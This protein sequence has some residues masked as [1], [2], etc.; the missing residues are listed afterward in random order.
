[1][2]DCMHEV[3]KK[4]SSHRN[5]CSN[6]DALEALSTW[7]NTGILIYTYVI[8]QASMIWI[9]IIRVSMSRTRQSNPCFQSPSPVSMRDKLNLKYKKKSER[10]RQRRGALGG[11]VKTNVTEPNRVSRV[12]SIDPPPSLLSPLSLSIPCP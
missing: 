11:G 8:T 6:F 2:A 4:Y 12:G 7:L 10:K 9:L 1:M 5:P 3:S